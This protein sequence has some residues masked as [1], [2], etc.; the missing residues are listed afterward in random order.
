MSE[1]HYGAVVE[2]SF[3]AI[4][5]SISSYLI[6]CVGIDAQSLMDH[7]SPYDVGRRF[8]PLDPATVDEIKRLYRDR[9]T[10]HYYDSSISTA[11]QAEAMH[12]LALSIHAAIANRDSVLRAKCT[13]D[14]NS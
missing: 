4:E 14:G 10:D 1:Q 12:E 5:H 13:C 3:I 6:E 9:R 2:Q 7:D 8:L 11:E